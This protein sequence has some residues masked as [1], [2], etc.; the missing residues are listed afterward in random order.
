MTFSEDLKARLE[1]IKNDMPSVDLSN[2][3][4]FR[5]Y[6]LLQ[7]HLMVASENLMEVALEASTGDL[8]AYLQE[9]LLEEKDHAVW[10]ADDL[11]CMGVDVRKTVASPDA[12]NIAGSVYYSIHHESPASLL[13]YM[14]FLE[15]FP[16]PI[17]HIEKLEELYGRA[18]I[19]TLRYHAVH[20]VDHAQDLMAVI[21][22]MSEED[23][24]K[25]RDAAVH[26]ACGIACAVSRFR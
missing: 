19:R 24:M 26:T 15:F 25:I 1:F 5:S 20:D 23:Q 3:S 7:Y 21:D 2:P 8:A 14:A 12:K 22:S 18:A 6:M 9:H 16:S 11:R 10:L 13:G 17:E 4:V